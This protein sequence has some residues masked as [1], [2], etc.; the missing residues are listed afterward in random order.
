[1]GQKAK[2]LRLIKK[3]ELKP[4]MIK[5]DKFNRHLFRIIPKPI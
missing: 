2:L 3:N 4:Y 1:M 5:D